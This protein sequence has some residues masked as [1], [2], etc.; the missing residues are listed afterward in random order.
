MSL[1]CSSFQPP[2]D[3][4]SKRKNIGVCGQVAVTRGFWT[5]SE[6]LVPENGYTT[7]LDGT[8]FRCSQSGPGSDSNEG[9]LCF[10]ESSSISGV[11][12][13]DCIM[14][15]PG[16]SSVGGNKPLQSSSRW[17]LH[18]QLTKLFIARRRQVRFIIFPRLLVLYEMQI[19]LIVPWGCLVNYPHP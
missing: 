8:L 1:I 7:T 17:V 9:V 5:N 10:L 15:L 3:M 2:L 11:S 16:H 13:S 4:K 19:V 6:I 12:P 14:S 18:P